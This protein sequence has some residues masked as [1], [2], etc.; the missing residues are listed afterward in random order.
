MEP[1]KDL[2][3]QLSARTNGRNCSDGKN[4]KKKTFHR[5]K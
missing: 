1:N 3:S 5:L 4:E 2:Q